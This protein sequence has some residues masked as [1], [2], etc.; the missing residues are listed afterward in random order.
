M[1]PAPARLPSVKTLAAMALR[2]EHGRHWYTEGVP[3]LETAAGVL[4][5]S[6]DVLADV[7]ALTSPRVSVRRNMG[8]AV[9]YLRRRET[10]RKLDS[11]AL[12]RALGCLPGVG[13]SLLHWEATGQIRGKKTGPFSLAVQGDPNALVLDTWMSKVLGVDQSKLFRKANH[14]KITKRFEATARRL[15]WTVAETQAAVWTEATTSIRTASG[16]RQYAESPTL[17]T[18][19]NEAT[20]K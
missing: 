17:G 13:A 9:R 1:A 12:G 18:L 2:G 20:T 6:T 19:L 5:V 8:L 14:A 3:A 10:L 15:G 7:I 16:R 11:H 4:G